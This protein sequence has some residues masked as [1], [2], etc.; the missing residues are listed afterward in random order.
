[1]SFYFHSS[2]VEKNCYYPSYVH[3]GWESILCHV[4]SC[5]GQRSTSGVSLHGSPL[6]FRIQGLSLH[7]EL[8]SLEACTAPRVA[9][10]RAC[11]HGWKGNTTLILAR[12][13]HG[14]PSWESTPRTSG[15]PEKL[16]SQQGLLHPHDQGYCLL[17][18][19]SV[20]GNRH[21]HKELTLYSCL[22]VEQ[23]KSFSTCWQARAGL[24]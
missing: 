21:T 17:G 8:T 24:L 6:Y 14:L 2:K 10:T 20:W 18:E 15:T 12:V 22:R 9:D 4:C 13:E 7:L 5:Q 19:I 11:A 16:G 1:M 3:V 23:L